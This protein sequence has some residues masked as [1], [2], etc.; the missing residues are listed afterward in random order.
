GGERLPARLDVGPRRRAGAAADALAVLANPSRGPAI[1]LGYRLRLR[2][3]R[4]IPPGE[5]WLDAIEGGTGALVRRDRLAGRSPDVL[6]GARQRR[7]SAGGRLRRDPLARADHVRRR[8]A[9]PARP[10]PR[11]RRQR[12]CTFVSEAWSVGLSSTCEMF[13]CCGR[14]A[15]QT[16]TSATSCAVS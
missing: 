1:R 4:R 8:R 13:T 6:P 15:T 2:P 7:V 12:R 14:V 10:A 16:I 3:V 11:A 9:A 5:P